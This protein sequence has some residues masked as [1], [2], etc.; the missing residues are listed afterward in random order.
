MRVAI[1]AN[2]W[3]DTMTCVVKIEGWGNV[4]EDHMDW[5]TT[6]DDDELSPALWEAQQIAHAWWRHG[7]LGPATLRPLLFEWA[8]WEPHTPPAA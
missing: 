1:T 2:R 7:G 3:T 6:V 4:P 8:A 5:R